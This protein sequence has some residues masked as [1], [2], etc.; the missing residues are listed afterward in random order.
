MILERLSYQLGHIKWQ[1]GWHDSPNVSAGIFLLKKCQ[2][3]HLI[4]LFQHKYE[5]ILNISTG[6]IIVLTKIG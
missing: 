6:Q 2:L 3:I 4:V 5:E 1:E